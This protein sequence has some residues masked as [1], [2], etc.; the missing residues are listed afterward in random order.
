[1][2]S[3]VDKEKIKL[4]H[5]T[6]HIEPSKIADICGVSVYEVKRVI[7]RE[8]IDEAIRHYEGGGYESA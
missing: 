4:L 8:W 1:M 3:Y 7:I 5:F 6:G 2:G